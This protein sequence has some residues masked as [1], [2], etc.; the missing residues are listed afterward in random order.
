[1]EQGKTPRRSRPLFRSRWLVGTATLALAATGVLATTL[2]ARAATLFGADFENGSLSGWSRSGGSW[3][4]ATDGSRVLEQSNASGDARIFAGNSNWANYTAQARVKATSGGSGAALFARSTSSTSFDRLILLANGQA[5]LQAVSGSSVTVLGTGTGVATGTWATLQLVEAGSTVTGYVNG[6]RIGSGT[7]QAAR[8][9]IGLQTL[10]TTARFDDVQVTDSTT[11]GGTTTT[12]TTTGGGGT[13]STTT[14]TGTTTT[15]TG[16]CISTGSNVADGWAGV[17]AWSQNGTTGGAGG[18]TVTVTN[19]SQFNQYA[20]ATAP[21][22]IQVSGTITLSKM[23]DVGSDKTV[24]GVGSGSGFSGYG[25]NIGIPISDSITSPPANAVHNVILRNLKITGSGD[26]NINVMMFSHHIWIDHNDL[27]D[28]NDGA[29]DIKRGSSYVTVSWNH[30]HDA[31]KNMLLGRDDA[32]SAQDTGR[33]LVSYHHNWFD[34]TTQRNPRV[35]YGNPVHVYNNYYANNSNYGIAS[36]IYAGVLV[37]GN[38]FENVKD[39]YHLREGDT[40]IDGT[41]VARDNYF[42]NSGTGITAGSVNPIGYAYTLDAAAGVKSI[43]SSGSGIGK[44]GVPSGGGTTT[45]CPGTTTTTTSQPVT[46]TTTTTTQPVTTTTTTTTT[47]TG[48]QTS[49]GPVGWAAQNGGTTGGAG[50]TT[51]TVTSFADFK[52]QAQA[53]GARTILV[54]GQLSGSGTVEITANKTIRGVGSSSGITGAILN[55]EDLSPAN[56]IIQNLNLHGVKG[57]DTIQ[58]ESATNIWI[59]HNT[60]SS[61]IES[62]PDVYDGLI[63]ITHAGNYVT[64]SWNVLKDHWKTSLV[65]HSDGN[66]GEDTGKLKVTYH[67]NWFDRTFERSP[68]IRFG[69]PVHV[70]NNYYSNIINDSASYAIASTM[71]AGVLV[72]GNVFE[73][74]N[75]ACWSASGYADSDAGRLVARNNLLTNSG[76]CETN[77]TVASIPYSYNLDDVN[78]VKSIVTGGAGA[79]RL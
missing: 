78:S 32:D 22:V 33:L 27:S 66:S 73:N 28:P 19:E 1:M 41:L 67:H 6:T 71:N 13:T 45:T 42:V 65:G 5:Q 17:N 18:A 8:G 68:R 52:T 79:G 40:S 50:G 15:T 43:V 49:G 36:T 70:Y 16:G 48:G 3:A 47:T 10:A 23:T 53:G 74:V 9:R 14:T 37:E 24:V 76:P 29:L 63:D 69:D 56:V 58:I 59:D 64:V 55:I 4:I 38:Y 31:D 39:P 21:Y 25:L 30:V 44:V 72:E 46:T 54:S 20:T 7:S 26:D 60:L 11:G 62:D 61:T 34:G 57:N 75:Q 12:T 51:V 2:T 35:R 77:G